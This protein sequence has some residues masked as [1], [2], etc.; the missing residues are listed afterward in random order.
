MD[1][2]IGYDSY[3]PRN[4]NT[5]SIPEYVEENNKIYD[6]SKLIFNASDGSITYTMYLEKI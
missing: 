3:W 5:I 6:K 4:F 1:C 2:G